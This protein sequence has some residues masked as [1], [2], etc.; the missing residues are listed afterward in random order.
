VVNDNDP[1]GEGAEK[2]EAGLALPVGKARVD[3]GT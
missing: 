3:L 2:I 1:A